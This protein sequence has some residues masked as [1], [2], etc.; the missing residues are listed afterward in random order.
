[1]TFIDQVK[2]EYEKKPV[3]LAPLV[4]E[5][6]RLLRAS[7]PTTIEMEVSTMTTS[8][9]VLANPTGIQQIIMNLATNAAY[10][11][12]ETGGKISITL[13]DAE[14]P[15]GLGLLPGPYV[16]LTVQ[17]TGVGMDASVMEKMYE[18]FF[19][20]KGVGQGT[21]M[22]LAVVYGI[23]KSL[24]GDIIVK[25]RPGE[26][27][28]FRVFLPKITAVEKPETPP[29]TE[30]PTGKERVLLVDDEETIT[31]LGTG[32][33]ERLGYTVTAVT[34]SSEA[35]KLFSENPSR[36]DLVITDQTMPELT[37]RRLASELLKIRPDLPIILCTGHSDSVN[38]ETAKAA[39][40]KNFLMKPLVKREL[41]VAVRRALDGVK[42]K[43][44]K[45]ITE[46]GKGQYPQI[47]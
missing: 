28:T 10:A 18:P 19:T 44:G 9:S 5:T 34:S 20:T 36:F 41:A 29:A 17:D 27:S 22:G 25:S 30:V 12:R 13:A 8:D 45:R 37:G 38:P 33:L 21:G 2:T 7:I 43:N 11:M 26:G 16:E 32:M 23:V 6:A 46:I 31:E 24:N 39:G 35:L 47:E 40:I 14:V 1:V 4:K 3:P 42:P 15:P